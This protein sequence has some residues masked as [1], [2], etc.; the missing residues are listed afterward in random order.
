MA[1]TQKTACEELVDGRLGNLLSHIPSYTMN[2]PNREALAESLRAEGRKIRRY[3]RLICKTVEK[4]TD[5]NI[6]AL[7]RAAARIQKARN[8]K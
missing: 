3:E 1:K 6:T 2:A 8:K 7:E 4:L 5:A